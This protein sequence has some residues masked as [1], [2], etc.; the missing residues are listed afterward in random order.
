MPPARTERRAVELLRA[1]L[2]AARPPDVFTHRRALLLSDTASQT[3]EAQ[4]A[5]ARTFLEVVRQ[6]LTHQHPLDVLGETGLAPAAGVVAEPSLPVGQGTVKSLSPWGAYREALRANKPVPDAEAFKLDDASVRTWAITALR[7]QVEPQHLGDVEKPLTRDGATFL[8]NMVRAKELGLVIPISHDSSSGG[9]LEFWNRTWPVDDA[10]A[11]LLRRASKAFGFDEKDVRF[12][13]ST[14]AEYKPPPPPPPKRVGVKRRPPAMIGVDLV[15]TLESYY[16][17][18]RLAR[19]LSVDPAMQQAVAL[20]V[21][22]LELPDD[23]KH[24]VRDFLA[25]QSVEAVAPDHVPLPTLHEARRREFEV[26]TGPLAVGVTP[27]WR[28]VNARHRSN[29]LLL[30]LWATDEA[31]AAFTGAPNL[32]L[33]LNGYKHGKPLLVEEANL[34]ARRIELDPGARDLIE[35]ARLHFS[36]GSMVAIDDATATALIRL[37]QAADLPLEQSYVLLKGLREPTSVTL[38]ALAER[39]GLGPRAQVHDAVASLLAPFG[40]HDASLVNRVSALGQL[41]HSRSNAPSFTAVVAGADALLAEGALL[42]LDWAEL[43]AAQQ[44]RVLHT[45]TFDRHRG[46]ANVL[47]G[48]FVRGGGAAFEASLDAALEG[49][50]VE[51]NWEW[52]GFRQRFEALGPDDKRFVVRDL[53]VDGTAFERFGLRLDVVGEAPVPASIALVRWSGLG[54][55]QVVD[56]LKQRARALG[57]AGLEFTLAG[58]QHSTLPVAL[59][60]AK[61]LDVEGAAFDVAVKLGRQ[62]LDANPAQ[63]DDAIVALQQWKRENDGSDGILGT[64]LALLH[65]RDLERV[66]SLDAVDLELGGVAPKSYKDPRSLAE[67][68]AEAGPVSNF[69]GVELSSFGALTG[70]APYFLRGDAVKKAYP[71]ADHALR[72]LQLQL[73]LKAAQSIDGDARFTSLDEEDALALQTIERALGSAL[74]SA[75]VEDKPLVYSAGRALLAEFRETYELLLD[76]YE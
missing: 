17:T 1:E 76:R 41:R 3:P 47:A 63:Q 9:P 23:V 59:E 2:D 45:L 65:E 49:V 33:V 64:V 70:I 34:L 24:F 72:M 18:L 37:A 8:R 4:R 36:Y 15:A 28:T 13:D 16:P 46:A 32:R 20:F 27:D 11:A 57:D 56:V 35:H 50:E 7:P 69:T 21:E 73:M 48:L 12:G 44:Q 75:S 67:R 29:E 42:P 38:A 62:A 58:I 66:R 74:H 43:S 54:V 14:L 19:R 51:G 40:S 6:G 68:A 25:S 30:P 53:T 31:V 52:N 22:R 10:T 55:E 26:P 61:K 39:L 71:H 5:Q 60:A